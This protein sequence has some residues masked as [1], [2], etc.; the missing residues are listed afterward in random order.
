MARVLK[1][2]HSHG[3]GLFLGEESFQIPIQQID[4]PEQVHA[5][6]LVGGIPHEPVPAAL[7]VGTKAT[8]KAGCA[9]R[10][11]RPYEATIVVIVAA[12][13]SGGTRRRR[14]RRVRVG[15]P[16]LHI[17]KREVKRKVRV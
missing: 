11:G 5:G 2:G 7:D 6:T 13:A 1:S 14:R 12:V 10:D 3:V 4:K 16:Q 17:E 9:N 8:E 15:D